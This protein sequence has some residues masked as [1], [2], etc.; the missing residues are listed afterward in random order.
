MPRGSVFRQDESKYGYAP[1]S[2][3]RLLPGAALLAH[4]LPLKDLCFRAD[5]GFPDNKESKPQCEK[6]AQSRLQRGKTPKGKV[7]HVSWGMNH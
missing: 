7:I 1:N 4:Q 5:G 3:F 6:D 2:N